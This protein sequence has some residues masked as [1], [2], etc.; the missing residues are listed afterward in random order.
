[1]DDRVDRFVAHEHS[2]HSGGA[3]SGEVELELG[4][5]GN[6]VP[7][8]DDE[9][10][11]DGGNVAALNEEAADVSADEAGTSGHIYTLGTSLREGEP[12]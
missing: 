1:M 9:I 10:V 11:N 5:P 12:R 6:A 2:E 3:G 7:Q 4:H 8:P